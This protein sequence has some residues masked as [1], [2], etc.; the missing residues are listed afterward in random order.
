M[1]STERLRP[2]ARQSRG[3]SG[4]ASSWRW[5]MA[6]TYTRTVR[7]TAGACVFSAL[8]ATCVM[9]QPATAKTDN[10]RVITD[11]NWEEILT[12]EWMIE[13]WVIKLSWTK[14]VC[15]FLCLCMLVNAARDSKWS[16]ISSFRLLHYFLLQC[17]CAGLKIE[18]VQWS[19]VKGIVLSKPT[20]PLNVDSK[21]HNV[22]SSLEHKR[23]C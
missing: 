16:K 18:E 8:I 15:V 5:N 22:L 12:G 9:L 21:P 6:C 4:K 23:R 17:S 20:T 19:E 3:G 14:K 1:T 7:M 2:S 11:G 10:L 13:L